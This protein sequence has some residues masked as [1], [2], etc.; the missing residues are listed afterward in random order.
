MILMTARIIKMLV[1]LAAL[2]GGY[3]LLR[4]KTDGRRLLCLGL[5][6]C[7]FVVPANAVAGVIPPLKETVVRTALGESCPEA[8]GQEVFLESYTIDGERHGCLDDLDIEDGHWFWIGERYCWRPEGDSRQPDGVTRSVVLN[9]P[10]G[11]ERTLD[12]AANEYRGK[13]Q[14][15]TADGANSWTVDTYGP[16]GTLCQEPI[17]RSASSKL[18][19]NQVRHLAAYAVTLFA[20]TGALLAAN[21]NLEK[22]TRLCKRHRGGIIFASIAVAQLLFSIR[23]AG[24]DCFWFDELFEIGWSVEAPNLLQRAFSGAA[25]LPI[26]G[27]IFDLW[28]KIAPY[29]EKWL[30]LI[31]EIGTAVGIFFV[32][33]SGRELKDERAGAIAATCAAVS[34]NILTQCSYEIRSYGLYF[35]GASVVLYLYLKS[36]R[37]PDKKRAK[38]IAAMSLAMVFFIGM[39]YHAVVSCIMFFVL[40]VVAYFRFRVKN[41]SIVPYLCAAASYIPNAVYI[42]KTRFIQTFTADTWQP[43]PGIDQ[44]Y[45]LFTYLAGEAAIVLAGVLIGIVA[46][47]S[48]AVDKGAHEKSDITKYKILVPVSLIGLV[49]TFFIVYGNFINPKA[50][51]WFNRYFCDLFPAF[52]VV[53]GY[54][55]STVCGILG[56]RQTGKPAGSLAVGVVACLLVLQASWPGLRSAA[57]WVHDPYRGAADWLYSQWND[58]Y[59]DS[60]LVLSSTDL[61]GPETVTGWSEYYLT[62]QGRRD[63]VNCAP[64]YLVDPGAL[65]QYA[66][67]YVVE[68]HEGLHLAEIKETLSSGFQKIG[69]N[70]AL[71][72]T[73]YQKI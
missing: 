28:Y 53:C 63:A 54:G 51:L 39:H 38:D 57:D 22:L 7:A 50:T 10:V 67:V 15:Q 26:Y 21:R 23:Y 47:F 68:L 11:W 35:M 1:L 73:V 5:I 44:I 18:I 49:V 59:N 37:E 27:T 20:L 61:G 2:A 24:T 60:T 14:I 12:F 31:S 45:Q 40:D 65:L 16:D 72:I 52:F 34:K 6:C 55:L 25:P 48:V 17:G 32:G 41:R 19:L 13:V 30:L 3:I 9:I 42:F 70:T 56:S 58:I 64:E 36:Y 29:G 4:G 71:K 46:A 69:E 62:R 33:M 66:R 8:Q 43:V